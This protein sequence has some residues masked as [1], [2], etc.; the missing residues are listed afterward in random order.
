MKIWPCILS[1]AFKCLG[2]PFLSTKQQEV[3]A[4][5]HLLVARYHNYLE[6]KI[7]CC[8]YLIRDF[9]GQALAWEN[10]DPRTTAAVAILCLRRV[11]GGMLYAGLVVE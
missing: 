11:S 9:L 3:C 2:V 4:S 1:W 5:H 8:F 10:T 6:A 7:S